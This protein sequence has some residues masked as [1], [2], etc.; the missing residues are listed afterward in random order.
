M[1]TLCVRSSPWTPTVL[2]G[3]NTAKACQIS[4]YNPASLIDWT[5]IS[6]ACRRVSSAPFAVTSPSTRMPKPGPGNGCLDRKSFGTC[7]CKSFQA[8]YNYVF[9][10]QYGERE[11]GDN[12]HGLR[13]GSQVCE[14]RLWTKPS[15]VQSTWNSCS[16]AGRQHYG[17][18]LWF[19]NAFGYCRGAGKIL[20]RRDTCIS[21]ER[22]MWRNIHIYIHTCRR[23]K[24]SSP[25]TQL[26]TVFLARGTLGRA[27]AYH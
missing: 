17:E 23:K 1:R 9:L 27:Q 21:R 4:S 7:V 19:S 10:W 13:A 24:S 11:L 6:S 16:L 8:I 20:L 22:N 3:I 15:V 12:S 2:C 5:K 26:R 14:L 18:T 25:L